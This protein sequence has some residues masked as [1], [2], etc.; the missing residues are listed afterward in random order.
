[1]IGSSF[2]DGM[3]RRRRL[4]TV[5][6]LGGGGHRGAAQVGMLRSLAEHGIRPDAVVGSSVG[7]LNAS[8]MAAFPDM[9][10]V[11]LLEGIWAS[12][13][14]EAVFRESRVR[15]LANR[16]RGRNYLRD[17]SELAALIEH[18]C[19]V[20]GIVSFEDLA[21]PLHIV[22]TDM[23]RGEKTVFSEGPLLRPL[24]ASTAVP[25][26]YPPVL[27]GERLYS[28]G[29]VSENTPIATAINLVPA[30]EQVIALDL[31][32]GTFAN[33]VLGWGEMLDRAVQVMLHQRLVADLH[34]LERHRITVICP[35]EAMSRRIEF[36]R[37]A[38]IMDA[39]KHATDELL[40]GGVALGAKLKP[41]LFYA[42]F[43]A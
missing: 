16:L 9:R 12:P 36:K 41:G 26:L 27:I 39:A 18:A 30:P 32:G 14:T 13:H 11:E 10:G 3:R 7:A 20:T 5:L 25:G 35:A 21:L 33:A 4:R 17:A 37:L 15:L 43:S 28:D 29:G 1:M 22:A 40:D 6:V 23:Q 42:S 24:L 34:R 19:A 38:A 31:M 2:L 8:V